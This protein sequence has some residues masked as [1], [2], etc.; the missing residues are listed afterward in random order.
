MLASLRRE[1]KGA[2]LNC[3]DDH[4]S[5]RT[6]NLPDANPGCGKRGSGHVSVHRWDI[7]G[8]PRHGPSEGRT[9]PSAPPS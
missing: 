3:F 4:I 9:R 5:D 8:D 7:G 1:A 2:A 6:G